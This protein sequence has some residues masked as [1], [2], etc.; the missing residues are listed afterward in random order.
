[1]RKLFMIL[2]FAGLPGLATNPPQKNIYLPTGRI[3]KPYEA[4]CRAVAVYESNNDSMRLNRKEMAFG[5]YQIRQPMLTEFNR[6][7][8]KTYVLQ[9]MFNKN[10]SKEVL[11]WHASQ[12]RPDEVEKISR[13]WNGGR[14]GMRKAS[15]KKYFE[16]IN[17]IL[18]SF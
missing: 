13:T 7:T 2:I 5:L 6:S 16:K 8:G 18:E 14:R 4:I 1:M 17:I 3:L 10:K 11:L 9:E 15:T 12:F